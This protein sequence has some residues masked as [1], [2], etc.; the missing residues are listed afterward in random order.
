MRLVGG[1]AV[2]VLPVRCTTAT[3]T[4]IRFCSQNGNRACAALP[5]VPAAPIGC[6]AVAGWL[7]RGGRWDVA[8]AVR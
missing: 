1:T 3:G 7:Q 5:L 6:H 2:P 4:T 8:A